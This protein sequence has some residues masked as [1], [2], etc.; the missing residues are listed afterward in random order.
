LAEIVDNQ[1]TEL[2]L[3]QSCA[4]ARGLVEKQ[5]LN[6]PAILQQLIGQH[7]DPKTDQLARLACPACGLGYMEFRARG[8]LGCPHDYAV[9]REG[10]DPLLHRVHRSTRHIGKSPRNG[11]DN[12]KRQVEIAT[13]RRQLQAAVTAEQY[14]EAVH[15]RDLLREKEAT[16][17]SG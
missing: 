5:D 3:C 2:H 12:A 4:E 9:F 7:L 17:E 16:Y 11:A 10:L 15:F 13:L 14:E 6:L 8:R 1:K